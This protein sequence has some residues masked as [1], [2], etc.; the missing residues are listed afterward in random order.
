MAPKS[1][2]WWDD[3]GIVE[4]DYPDYD[5]EDEYFAEKHRRR[6]H[7]LLMRLEPGHPDEEMYE[8]YDEE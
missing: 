4:D 6:R 2:N 7:N 3:V 8:D 5:Y 1:F